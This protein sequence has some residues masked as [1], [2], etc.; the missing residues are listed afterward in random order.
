M[1]TSI[2]EQ[3]ELDCV[4]MEEAMEHSRLEDNYDELVIRGC[5]N[6]AHSLVERWLN[7]KLSSTKILAVQEYY[8]LKVKLPYAPIKDI[9]S[10]TAL[11]SKGDTVTLVQG[12]DFRVDLVRNM[13]IF[14]SDAYK[15]LSEFNITYNCGYETAAS[16]PAGIHHAI[17]MTFAT[18]YEY[19]EDSIVG[20]TLSKVHLP[21]QKIIQTFKLPA[22][23]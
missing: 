7:R 19:R 22:M 12:T 9:I 20:G 18:L 13:V 3:S 16:I 1:I 23:V 5:L 11:D 14:K 6:A 17:K 2:L 10:V 4:T 8:K 21:T 15:Y